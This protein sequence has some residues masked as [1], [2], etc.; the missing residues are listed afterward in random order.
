MCQCRHPTSPG[1]GRSAIGLKDTLYKGTN[2]QPSLGGGDDSLTSLVSSTWAASNAVMAARKKTIL[3][4]F[5]IVDVE[6]LLSVECVRFVSGFNF[7]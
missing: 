6:L 5:F 7:V 3:K 2:N 4:T 1:Q